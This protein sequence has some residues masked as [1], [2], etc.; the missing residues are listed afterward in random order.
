M[1]EPHVGTIRYFVLGPLRVRK[2]NGSITEVTQGKLSA[3]L[4]E[5]LMRRNGWVDSRDLIEALWGAAPPKTVN[6]NLKGYVFRLR[7]LLAREGE[8]SPIASGVGKY[9]L[10]VS[11]DELDAD[12]FER[13]VA[14]GKAALDDGETERAE[15]YLQDALSL[16]QG[17]MDPGFA[18]RHVG[19]G[20]PN[21]QEVRRAARMHLAGCRTAAGRPDEAVSKLRAV[22]AENPIDERAWALLITALMQDGRR[23]EASTEYGE[24]LEHIR[25]ATGGGP[26]KALRAVFPELVKQSNEPIPEPVRETQLQETLADPQ[27]QVVGNPTPETEA[28]TAGAG[29]AAEPEPGDAAAEGAQRRF[30]GR[31]RDR[32]VLATSLTACAM[33]VLGAAVAAPALFNTEEDPVPAELRLGG[34]APRRSVPHVATIPGEQPRLL[35]GMGPK[36]STADQQRLVGQAPIGMLTTWFDGPDELPRY[37]AWSRD[38]VPGHYARGKAMHLI[39]HPGFESPEQVDTVHGPACGLAYPLS[40]GFLDDMRRLATAFAGAPDGPPLYV[41]V[42]DGPEK[43]ICGKDQTGYNADPQTRNYYDALKDR[44]REVRQI[45]HRYAP[46]ARVA[47]NWNGWQASHDDPDI[48][49]GRSLMQYFSDVLAISDFQS[50]NAFESEDNSRDVTSMVDELGRYGPIMVSN[51]GPN[52]D[53]SGARARSDLS[54]VFAPDRISSLTARG[55]FAWSFWQEKYVE[56]SPETYQMARDIVQRYGR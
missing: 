31:L 20:A 38:L 13:L 14:R 37:E 50:F 16:W 51:F 1:R 26:G 21:L 30:P 56:S 48:G 10:T 32:W 34:T 15:R 8:T 22:V 54:Q 36:A 40:A 39:I 41:S 11:E 46:N 17:F 25:A 27:P 18:D 49:E 43:T 53:E 33:L 45:F 44:Y 5:L 12:V 23:A 2:S 35:F 42:L 7:G 52:K 47:L 29:A 6:A 24:A 28:V 19:T 4:I 3:L 9:R 55:L